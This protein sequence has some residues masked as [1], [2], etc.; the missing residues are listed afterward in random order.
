MGDG[1]R[2]GGGAWVTGARGEEEQG[3]REEGRSR[4]WEEEGSRVEDEDEGRHEQG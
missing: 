3:R 1:S 4:G 2:R